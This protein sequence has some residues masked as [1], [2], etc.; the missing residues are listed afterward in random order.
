VPRGRHALGVA[1]VLALNVAVGLYPLPLLA[2]AR[3]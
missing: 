3:L 1:A 2:A